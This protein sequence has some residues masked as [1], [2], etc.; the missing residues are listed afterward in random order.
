VQQEISPQADL[1]IALHARRSAQAVAAWHLTGKPLVLVL[2]GTDV[3]RDIQTDAAAQQSLSAATRLVVLQSAALSEVP[4]AY[5]SKTQVIYQSAP[6]LPTRVKPPRPFTLCMVGHLRDEKDPITFIHAAEQ[7]A[8]RE[9]LRFDHYGEVL[10][11]AFI[12]P[13]AAAGW[14]NERYQWHGKVTHSAART[15]MQ[16]AH[17]SVICSRMEGGAQVVLESIMAGTP[18]LASRISGNIGMLGEDYA[19]Y[20]ELGDV[21]GLCRLIERACND[22]LFLSLLQS[23]CAARAHLFEPERERQAV[24]HL[25]QSLL[26]EQP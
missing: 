5:R 1:L 26:P 17:L 19:G 15:A 2:T 22:A 14:H 9:Q 11:K 10:D 16:Q 21:T 7:L 23:Q 18:V 8:H 25:V 20:F 3:Y 13:V 12:A 24:L 4:P 6:R